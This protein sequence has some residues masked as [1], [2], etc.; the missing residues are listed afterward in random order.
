[1]RWEKIMTHL[2]KRR[3]VIIYLQPKVMLILYYSYFS[4]DRPFQFSYSLII[5]FSYMLLLGRGTRRCWDYII[6]TLFYYLLYAFISVEYE[7]LLSFYLKKFTI[8]LVDY[9]IS[10]LVLL[11][12][13]SYLIPFSLICFYWSGVR[14]VEYLVSVL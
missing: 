12:Y 9:I 5:L 13:Y 3:I 7:G 8:H 1:M 6:R 10:T 4:L 2:W 11:F 14:V